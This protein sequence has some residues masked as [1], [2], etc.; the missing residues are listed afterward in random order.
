VA[1]LYHNT[2]IGLQSR[3]VISLWLLSGQHCR[4]IAKNIFFKIVEELIKTR[5][6][7]SSQPEMAKPDWYQR[8]LMDHF[9]WTIAG[10]T[11]WLVWAKYIFSTL[12]RNCEKHFLAIVDYW[13]SRNFRGISEF[14]S[15][16]TRTS[17]LDSNDR[18]TQ[19]WRSCCS[20]CAA[21]CQVPGAQASAQHFCRRLLWRTG[22]PLRLMERIY[23]P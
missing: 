20:S 5:C 4:G 17:N 16:A 13:H 10:P 23:S 15:N 3:L 7:Y 9:H 22:R 14:N 6:P 11:N 19:L 8:V 1:V 18:K 12:S 2:S 21:R